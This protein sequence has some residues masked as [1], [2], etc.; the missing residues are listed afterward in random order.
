MSRPQA[1][2]NFLDEL[3]RT[4]TSLAEWARAKKLP[5][6]I[7]YR[8]ARNELKGVRGDTRRV[9]LAMG[10]EVPRMFGRLRAMHEQQ[11]AASAGASATRER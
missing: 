5:L 9:M 11:K 4:N 6:R 3:E 10:L 7:V 8:V 1:L 2:V